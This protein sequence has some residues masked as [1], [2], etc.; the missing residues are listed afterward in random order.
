[1]GI[2]SN[3]RIVTVWSQENKGREWCIKEAD[4]GKMVFPVDKK[5]RWSLFCTWEQHVDY[6][7]YYC[8]L[9]IP[10]PCW[11]L[12][13]IWV[14]DARNMPLLLVAGPSFSWHR[15]DLGNCRTADWLMTESLHVSV[16]TVEGTEASLGCSDSKGHPR[17][18]SKS[19]PK[20][21]SRVVWTW[22]RMKKKHSLNI[23]QLHFIMSWLVVYTEEVTSM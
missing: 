10:F 7:N 6:I 12:H 20:S 15:G 23:S 13:W 19:I 2:G 1:M 16:L 9:K 11:F 21:S 8:A 22:T 3:K 14:L 18:D 5:I 17:C 4:C